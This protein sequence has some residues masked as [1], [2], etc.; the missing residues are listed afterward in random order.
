MKKSKRKAA[1]KIEL[2]FI[3]HVY[4]ISKKYSPLAHI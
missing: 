4:N 3:L 1:V 2:T